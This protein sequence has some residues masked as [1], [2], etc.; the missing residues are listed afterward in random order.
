MNKPNTFSSVVKWGILCVC[1]A[2]VWSISPQAAWPSESPSE[3]NQ[4]AGTDASSNRSAPATMSQMNLQENPE[5]LLFM[6]L[7]PAAPGALT[8]AERRLDPSTVTTITQEQIY[9]SGARNL[10]ELMDIYVPNLQLTADRF[11]FRHM[12]LR[13]INS[14]REDKYLLLVNGREMNEHTQSGAI[15]E[16]D[17]PMLSDIHHIDIIRGPGS[18]LYGAGAI[19]MVINMVTDNVNT[20]EGAQA[21]TRLG[22]VEEF[23]SGEMKYGKKLGPDSGIFLAGGATKYLG[24][25]AKDAPVYHSWKDL[26]ILWYDDPTAEHK[27][28]PRD[29]QAYQDL[30]KHKY[31]FEY[32][33]GDF[34]WWTRYTRGGEDF[35]AKQLHSVRPGFYG[36]GYQQLTTAA[37]YRQNITDAFSLD[38]LASYDLFD[39]ER[40]YRGRVETH[41][42]DEYLGQII[43]RWKC[44]EAHSLALGGALNYQQFGRPSPGYPHLPPRE[45]LYRDGLPRW[46]TTTLSAFGEHQWTISDKWTTFLGARV[47]NNTFTRNMYSQRFTLVHTPTDKDTLKFMYGQSVRMGFAAEMKYTKEKHGELTDPEKIGAYEIRYERRLTDKFWLAGSVFYHDYS[48]TGYDSNV[49]ASANLGDLKTC[50]AEVEAVYQS[51]RWRCS[52]SQGYTQLI[53]YQ[54]RPGVDSLISSE[55][56]GFGKNLANWNN[57]ITKLATHFQVTPKFGLDGSLRVYW[58]IPGGEDFCAYLD[59]TGRGDGPYPPLDESLFG[60]SIFLNLG[61]NY[62]ITN[63][64][65]LR[66]DGYNLMGCFDKKLNRLLFTHE[67]QKAYRASAAA[68]GVSLRY[69]F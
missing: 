42:E 38:Y 24:A 18:P 64:L 11:G 55:P 34:C 1:L 68:V 29:R 44:T 31:H 47:D 13:G 23:Y 5:M 60:P 66:V 65:E 17:L 40:L 32:T 12:G 26:S 57:H 45:N 53:N 4:S 62:R 37:Q 43:G 59:A 8:E 39:Y 19:A 2:L 14:F 36:E 6:D 54:E 25:D 15:S 30:L 27:Q 20:F 69:T 48:M 58:G 16:R 35:P 52:L 67:T 56:Y 22:A 61:A 63:R 9:N 46:D 7:P 51:T 49:D 33:H 10:D 21:T 50:G 28:I 3:P 41:R